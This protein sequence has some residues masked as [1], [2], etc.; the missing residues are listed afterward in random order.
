MHPTFA[1]AFVL[2]FLVP[3]TM[4]LGAFVIPAIAYEAG[5]RIWAKVT[6]KKFESCIVW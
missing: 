3:V 5:G 2:E 1:D 4:L 6:G